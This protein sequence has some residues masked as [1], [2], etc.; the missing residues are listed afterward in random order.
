MTVTISITQEYQK[1]SLTYKRYITTDE[2]V[3]LAL[4]LIIASGH[5]KDNVEAAVIELAEDYKSKS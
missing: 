2:L 4:R 3:E 5:H 1:V